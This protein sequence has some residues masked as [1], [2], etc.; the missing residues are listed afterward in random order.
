MYENAFPSVK[1]GGLRTS[2][3]QESENV[4]QKSLPKQVELNST[5]AKGITFTD[6]F[7]IKY[8]FKGIYP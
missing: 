4:V 5:W 7:I 3:A 1:H 2:K 6:R 8:L